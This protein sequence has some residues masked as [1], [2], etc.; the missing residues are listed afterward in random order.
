[1]SDDYVAAVR[2]R[3]EEEGWTES[4]SEPV[5][6]VKG[7][8]RIT[9]LLDEQGPW[10]PCVT[11]TCEAGTGIPSTQDVLEGALGW[12]LN[13]GR[14]TFSRSPDG[15]LTIGYAGLVNAHPVNPIEFMIVIGDAE[16]LWNHVR[17]LVSRAGGQMAR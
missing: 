2:S 10:G 8:M 9:T 6:W 15:T 5:V 7:D 14:P 1:M 16:D 3:M 13:V 17:H 12:A 4:S 11:V